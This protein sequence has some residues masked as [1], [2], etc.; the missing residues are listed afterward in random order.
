MLNAL[1]RLF[2][3]PGR[4]QPS[5]PEKAT[6][7][8]SPGPARA[9]SGPG[10]P[11]EAPRLDIQRS[12]SGKVLDG[13]LQNQHQTLVPLTLRLNRLE[14]VQ[15]EALMRFAAVAVLST[16]AADDRRRAVVTAWL[17]SVGA[18]DEAISLFEA[19]LGEPPALSQAMREVGDIAPQAYAV[20]VV[21]ADQH[22]VSGRLFANYVAARFVLP[23]DAV[24]SIDRRFRR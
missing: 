16:G 9:S 20:A 14:Q 22:E 18:A 7:V 12:L 15:V 13:W 17:R 5:T 21:G 8:A 1:S 3:G 23:A 11:A 24:R 10:A 19:S 4:S 2:P 6:D